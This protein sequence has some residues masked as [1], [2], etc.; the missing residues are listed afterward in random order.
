MG[1]EKVAG[2]DECTNEIYYDANSED[3]NNIGP[4]TNTT[5]KRKCDWHDIGMCDMIGINAV[6]NCQD[7]VGRCKNYIHHLCQIT[8]LTKA[9]S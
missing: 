6:D 9:L 4:V 3:D 2:D 7:S 5:T 8:Y 1:E